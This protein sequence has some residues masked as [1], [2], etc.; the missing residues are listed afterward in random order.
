MTVTIKDVPK[1][2]G[3]SISTVSYALSGKRPIG[4]KTRRS[5]EAAIAELGYAPNAGA[6]ALAGRRTYVLAVTQQLRPHTYVPAHLSFIL[7]TA[8]AARQFDYHILLL[9]QGEAVEG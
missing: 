9:P 6:Q 8:Q 4:E 5:I 1:A 2:A 7:A 3:V